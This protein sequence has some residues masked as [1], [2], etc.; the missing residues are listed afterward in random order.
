MNFF[1]IGGLELVVVFLIA[2]L[3]VGPTRLVQGAR[4]ARKYMTE[5]RRQREELTQMVEEAVDME[6][7]REQLD[8][9]GLMD[10]VRDLSSELNEFRQDAHSVTGDVADLKGLA[11]SVVRPEGYSRASTQTASSATP[12]NAAA[13][14]EP[15]DDAVP[16]SSNKS[17]GTMS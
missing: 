13:D 4:T 14:K 6:G 10:E 3:V 8:Q 15:S 2:L 1:G 16:A 9:E 7:I 17:E 5:L 11:R 12:D